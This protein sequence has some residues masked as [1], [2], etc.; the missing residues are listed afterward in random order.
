M[1]ATIKTN[2]TGTG[3]YLA[4]VLSGGIRHYELG[5]RVVTVGRD[6]SNAAS[7]SDQRAS[8]FHCVIE[9]LPTGRFRVRDLKSRNGTKVN[10]QR[11]EARLLTPG[12]T[13]SVGGTQINFRDQRTVP[14]WFDSG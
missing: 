5:D 1:D 10:G 13:I 9:S 14:Q 3:C 11:V 12:D 4:V 6:E 7:V 2:S 8:R